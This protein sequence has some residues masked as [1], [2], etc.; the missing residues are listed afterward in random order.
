M[1]TKCENIRDGHYYG[2]HCENTNQTLS[3]KFTNIPQH[4]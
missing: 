4:T 2:G 3:K 1:D